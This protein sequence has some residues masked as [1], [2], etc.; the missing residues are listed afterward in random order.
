MMQEKSASNQTK[1]VLLIVWKRKLWRSQFLH[2]LFYSLQLN[3]EKECTASPRTIFIKNKANSLTILISRNELPISIPPFAYLL[4]YGA[5]I[6]I[7]IPSYAYWTAFS[8]LRCNM[9]TICSKLLATAS[10]TGVDISGPAAYW[11]LDKR[12][13]Q[14]QKYSKNIPPIFSSLSLRRIFGGSLFVSHSSSV[15]SFW[16]PLSIRR[17]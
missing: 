15:T 13:V 7:A 10:F 14:L 1:F 9:F 12:Q 6:P 16:V 8:Y 2:L 3:A 4:A 11:S 5:P 17:I